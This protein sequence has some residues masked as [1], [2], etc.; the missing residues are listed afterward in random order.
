MAQTLEDLVGSKLVIG[1]PGTKITP[2]I[3]QHFK[4]THAGGVI[5]YRINFE[6]PDQLRKMIST[7]EAALGRK[8]LVCVDH[9]GG[10]VIMYRDGVTIFPDNLAFGQTR[11]VD[12]ARQAGQIAAKELRALGTDVNFAPVLDVLT[13]SYSP[14]IGIRSFGED[15]KLVSD[16]GAAYIQALQAGGVSATAKHFPGKGHA[17]VDAHLKLPTIPSTWEEMKEVHLQP[18][19]RAIQAGVDVIMSSHPK[20]PK[21]DPNP[22]NIATFSRR[23][24]TDCLRDELGFKG[25]ISSD[26][27]EM[28]A[29][30]EMC[31]IEVA[32]V[33]TVAAGHD[34]ILSCHDFDSQ[35]KCFKGML[36]AYKGKLLP[37]NE[38]EESVDRINK[39]KTKRSQRFNGV[40][41]V[42]E[43]GPKLAQKVSIEAVTVIQDHQKLLPLSNALRQDVGIVFPQLSSF[44]QKIMI[45]KP[46]EDEVGFFHEILGHLPEKHVTEVYG[47]TPSEEDIENCSNLASRSTVTIFFCFDAHLYPKEQAL[48]ALL[49]RT[50][51]KLVVVLMRDPYDKS[52]LRPKDTGITAF[53]FRR[54]Q[55]EAVINRI[56]GEE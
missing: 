6:S 40:P 1:V 44:S 4:A 49:Q 23:I 46:F 2:E 56:Y 47:I 3:V 27:L 29:I 42:H 12:Y 11:N 13:S 14:N 55:I 48:L 50:A 43:E 53:G 52:F 16:M 30:K 33:K 20:Y 25:I 26:D 21:L 31:P 18:F 41:S 15:W 45:E 28:G 36:E 51:R 22:G 24:M 38:L 8:L 7:L 9:E 34:L 35:L 39:L 19:I 37:I 10:R 17:P 5:F 32:A 54:C